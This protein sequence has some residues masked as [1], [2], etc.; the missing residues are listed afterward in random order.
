MGVS[1]LLGVSQVEIQRAEQ[2][3]DDDQLKRSHTESMTNATPEASPAFALTVLP[4]L[5][6]GCRS[7]CVRGAL[8]AYLVA[9]VVSVVAFVTLY[10][11]LKGVTG[12]RYAVGFCRRG[13][14]IGGDGC[15]SM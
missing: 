5:R 12:T 10:M 8:A 9:G 11:T 2:H 6:H 3:P 15:A 1:A 4:A 7:P 13:G 14:L